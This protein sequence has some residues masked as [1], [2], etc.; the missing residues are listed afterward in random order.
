MLNSLDKFAGRILRLYTNTIWSKFNR[1]GLGIVGI[2]LLPIA[3]YSFIRSGQLNSSEYIFLCIFSIAIIINVLPITA[4]IYAFIR[5]SILEN[6]LEKDKSYLPSIKEKVANDKPLTKHEST[7]YLGYIN[8]R[9]SRGEK[10]IG[11]ELAAYL[12]SSEE[13]FE[14]F[15][16]RSTDEDF[17]FSLGEFKKS[18]NDQEFTS[19]LQILYKKIPMRMNRLFN[20]E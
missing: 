15:L 2:V 1:T 6:Q 19:L 10:L 17:I 7:F 16:F 4:G 18:L 5:K 9:K 8:Q 11:K 12:M 20:K 14:E 3:W 13:I